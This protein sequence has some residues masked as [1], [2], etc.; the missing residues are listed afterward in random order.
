M[1]KAAALLLPLL[2]GVFCTGAATAREP[3]RQCWLDAM[4]DAE[5]RALVLGFARI[6]Q[7]EGKARAAAWAQEQ[8]AH[9]AGRANASGACTSPD[10]ATATPSP[11]PADDRNEKPPL[12]NRAGKPCRRIEM[13]NQNVP[14]VGGSMGWSLMAVC[15]D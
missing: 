7:A 1:R 3:A 10:T 6:Q 12:L 5:K 2:I 11:A 8:Q 15:K 4:S 9:Y 14:N 13:E